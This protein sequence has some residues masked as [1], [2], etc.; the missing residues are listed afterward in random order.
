MSWTSFALLNLRFSSLIAQ[1]INHRAPQQAAPA[2]NPAPVPAT[3]LSD[4]EVERRAKLECSAHQFSK[5]TAYNTCLIDARKWL[6]NP[7]P[8]PTPVS[9][10][11]REQALCSLSTGKTVAVEQCKREAPAKIEARHKAA[12]EIKTQTPLE[13]RLNHCRSLSKTVVAM[14]C[15]REARKEFS[16]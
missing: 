3:T 4:A 6:K 10:L 8:P 12:V 5:L 1:L 15:E 13:R 11:E 9:E 2:P 7:P 16:K 14:Q